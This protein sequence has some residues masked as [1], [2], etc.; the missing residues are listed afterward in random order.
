[1]ADNNNNNNNNNTH[2]YFDQCTYCAWDTPSPNLT[3]VVYIAVC[4]VCIITHPFHNHLILHAWHMQQQQQQH[5][6]H[7]PQAEAPD[8]PLPALPP[9]LNPAGKNDSCKQAT[10]EAHKY[11]CQC[12]INAVCLSA[13]PSAITH[14]AV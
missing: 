13:S 14:C 5:A 9:A 10:G 2:P 11:S 12:T 7:N 4:M 1:L 6:W 8:A 3:V